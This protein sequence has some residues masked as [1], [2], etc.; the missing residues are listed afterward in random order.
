MLGACID[1]IHLQKQPGN[2]QDIDLVGVKEVTR[3]KG[4]TVKVGDYN[5]YYGKGNKN[6]LGTGFFCTPQNCISS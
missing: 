3:D 2:W 6:Q 5:Y 4:G 1:Q